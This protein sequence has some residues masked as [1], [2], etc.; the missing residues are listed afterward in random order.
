VLRG[1]PPSPRS[2]LRRR[3]P[4]RS[5]A[6]RA[7]A[8]S[9]EHGNAA[10]CR[11]RT[12]EN[13]LTP[14]KLRRQGH[15]AASRHLHDRGSR[16]FALDELSPFRS[17]SALRQEDDLAFRGDGHVESASRPRRL[18]L[19]LRF[20]SPRHGWPLPRYLADSSV[21]FRK[22]FRTTA[23]YFSPYSIDLVAPAPSGARIDAI[24]AAGIHTLGA[25]CTISLDGWT[26]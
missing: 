13:D 26:S 24:A 11:S 16:S 25:G 18:A 6:R 21:T 20:T 10:A 4:R 15:S 9:R 12:G 3:V 23:V 19:R 17:G 22:A 8:G 7:L 2:G 14:S 5:R 1:I